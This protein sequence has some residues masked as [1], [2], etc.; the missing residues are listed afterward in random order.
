MT[1]L[2]SWLER[3]ASDHKFADSILYVVVSLGKTL[4]AYFLT[5]FLCG[6]ERQHRCLFHNDIYTGKKIKTSGHGDAGISES[7]SG[8]QLS[9][10]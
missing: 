10:A 8:L 9:Y 1:A 4:N 3:S 6:V 2:L 7:G 5:G